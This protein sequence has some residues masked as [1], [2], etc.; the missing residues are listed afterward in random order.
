MN[1]KKSTIYQ[2]MCVSDSGVIQDARVILLNTLVYVQVIRKQRY[3]CGF[4]LGIDQIT[5]LYFGCFAS[6]LGHLSHR[7]NH[8][9]LSSPFL[10][11]H[12]QFQNEIEAQE[13]LNAFMKRAAKMGAKIT[14]IV[15]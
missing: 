9:S 12:L 6:P 8:L 10:Q 5:D 3:P 1:E 13:F 7:A 14:P 15:E 2:V 11:F 4:R